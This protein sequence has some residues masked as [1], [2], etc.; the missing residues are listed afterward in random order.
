MLRLYNIL[1]VSDG[2]VISQHNDTFFTVANKK[3]GDVIYILLL[4]YN[5][6]ASLVTMTIC[7]M[8]FLVTEIDDQNHIYT[9]SLFNDCSYCPII[10]ALLF[11]FY[12]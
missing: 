4:A 7:I 6:K 2:I 11:F 3:E 12:C 1:Y 8:L 10:N 5:I 9:I